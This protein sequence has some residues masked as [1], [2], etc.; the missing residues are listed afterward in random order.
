MRTECLAFLPWWPFSTPGRP[1]D[2]AAA[3]IAYADGLLTNW[4]D[5]VRLAPWSWCKAASTGRR[6]AD[7]AVG[8]RPATET[9]PPHQGHRQPGCVVSLRRALNTLPRWRSR[10]TRD[11]QELS[12]L[13]HRP[14]TF[15]ALKTLRAADNYGDGEVR[16]LAASPLWRILEAFEIDDLTDSLVHRKDASRTVPRSR[17]DPTA[18]DT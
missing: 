13:Y 6:A 3:R 17:S 8:P 5:A 11:F 2:R 10:V 18:S 4:P 1:E 16:A 14:E 7:L 12:F 9:Q 15:P